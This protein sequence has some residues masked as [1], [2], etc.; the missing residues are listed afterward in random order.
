MIAF[1]ALVFGALGALGACPRQISIAA[2][3]SGACDVA[4]LSRAWAP[5]VPQGP[6][7]LA[8][9]A[10]SG[11]DV[12]GYFP[13]GRVTSAASGFSYFVDL[14]TPLQAA[15]LSYDVY[16]A[17]GFDWTAGGVL[18][19]LCGLDCPVGCGPLARGRGWSVQ[20]AWRTD[21]GVVSAAVYPDKPHA[22][23]CGEDWWWSNALQTGRWH[24]VKLYVRVNTPGQPDGVTRG[25]IDGRLVLDRRDVL[26]RYMSSDSYAVTRVSASTF[27]G[28]SDAALFAPAQ[29]QFVRF[30]NFTVWEGDCDVPGGV[31]V[32]LQATVVVDV[33]LPLATGYCATLRVDGCPG[34]ANVSATGT[35]SVTRYWGLQRSGDGFAAEPGVSAG[36]CVQGLAGPDSVS[37]T[38]VCA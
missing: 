20:P 4:A 24:A 16:F 21:G 11:G 32:P 7:Q 30:A 33:S 18:P 29:S 10:F 36:V 22:F 15:T 3:P 34:V 26:F 13:Q 5:G 14:P 6:F 12:V 38:A 27:A 35:G 19:G 8:N 25:W 23:P 31:E 2:A 1:A 17:P 37:W 9:C 28:G